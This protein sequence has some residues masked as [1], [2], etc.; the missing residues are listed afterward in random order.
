LARFR[1]VRQPSYSIR[2]DSKKSSVSY[3]VPVAWVGE[4]KG[5]LL[6]R[7]RADMLSISRGECH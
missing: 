1:A 2:H 3:K 7:A 6:L 4:S 5:V